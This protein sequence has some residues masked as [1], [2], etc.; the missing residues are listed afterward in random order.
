M[1]DHGSFV[2]LN[3]YVPNAGAKQEEMSLRGDLKIRFLH[4][5]KDRCDSLRAE[6]REVTKSMLETIQ[7]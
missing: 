5:L 2:L 1:T 7:F 4:A 3:C 6:G